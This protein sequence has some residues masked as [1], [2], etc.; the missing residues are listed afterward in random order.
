MLSTAQDQD[1]EPGPDQLGETPGLSTGLADL[2][3]ES[4]SGGTAWTPVASKELSLFPRPE[5]KPGWQA[6]SSMEA[7]P[8]VLIMGRSKLREGLGLA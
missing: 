6:W 1:L 3:V 7:R 5:H 8:H 2:G 4:V